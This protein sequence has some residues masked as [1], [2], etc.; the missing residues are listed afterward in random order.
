MVINNFQPRPYQINFL[1]A[2]LL[3]GYRNLL[4]INH[5][6][7][8]KDYACFN[9][10]IPLMLERPIVVYYIFPSFALGRRILWDNL[11]IEGN[12]VLSAIPSHMIRS[13]NNQTMQI[14]LTNGSVFNV[15]GAQE[16][17]KTLI[18]TNI[19]IAV[20]SEYR[21]INPNVY[22]YLS[23][24]ILASQGRCI[25]LSTPKGHNHLYDMWRKVKDHPAWFVE[26]L[27]VEDT[28]AIPVEEI[29]EE[30]KQGKISRDVALQE[31]WCDFDRGQD[32]TYYSAILETMRENGQITSV[33]YDPQMGKVYTSWDLG[34]NDPTVI[35]WWQQSRNQNRINIIDYYSA[36]NRSIDHFVRVVLDKPYVY[37]KHFPPHDIMVREQSVGV[38]RREIYKRLGISFEDPIAVDFED[39]IEVVKCTLP[40]IWIDDKKCEF[41][42]K[43]LENYRQE[44]DEINKRYYDRPVHDDYSHPADAL[45]YM[46]LA[47]PTIKEGM[48]AADA[49]AMYHRIN[50]GEG[51]GNMMSYNKPWW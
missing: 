4:C 31:Y 42:V 7:S 5:R 29:E 11:D 48:T 33:P 49:A 26:R 3:D 46:C 44:Y 51:A 20:F 39:G 34:I 25:F 10:L 19:H 43:T 36:C 40:K 24:I 2:L 14:K 8:G 28:K 38:T 35:I 41:L 6:R 22:A 1:N 13:M 30:I 32:Q 9:G 27:T 23:P 21:R 37:G 47:L 16:F 50:Y 18:G 17:D 15:M 45:R 12:R